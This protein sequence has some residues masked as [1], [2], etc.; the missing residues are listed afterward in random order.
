MQAVNSVFFFLSP[1]WNQS[2]NFWS[3]FPSLVTSMQHI[4]ELFGGFTGW[5]WRRGQ[6]QLVAFTPMTKADGNQRRK[7]ELE[8][9]NYQTSLGGGES[10]TWE[11]SDLGVFLSLLP[12]SPGSVTQ[13]FSGKGVVM[14]TELALPLLVVWG[15][16]PSC[17]PA[18]PMLQGGRGQSLWGFR[19]IME[20]AEQT[21]LPRKNR[22]QHVARTQAQDAAEPVLELIKI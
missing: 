16:V 5:L 2:P 3:I 22:L 7:A 17:T 4:T 10:W 12:V 1:L 18:V 14:A 20:N 15:Q 8:K 6:K 11:E 21:S 9:V 13:R 19:S